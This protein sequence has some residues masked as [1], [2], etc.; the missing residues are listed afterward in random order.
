MK[1][2]MAILLMAAV[3]YSA[4]AKPAAI[5]QDGMVL[6]RER[7]VP[8]WGTEAP[9]AK[10]T[11]SFAGQQKSAV[12]DAAG[13]WR[14]DFD[15]MP[16]CSKPRDLTIVSSNQ[17]ISQSNNRTIL[18]DV[19]VGEVW[20]AS[21]QS[22]MECPIWNRSSHYRD[23]VGAMK[24]AMTRRDDVR[25]F[26]V[27]R[28]WAL[29]PQPVVGS[30]RKFVPS[31]FDMA[32]EDPL[33]SAI[34]FYYALEINQALGVPV[35]I[36]DTCWC[37]TNID[38]W[39][40]LE[41][42]RAMPGLEYVANWKHVTDWKDAKGTH[43]ICGLRQQP[44]VL[45]NGMVADLVPFACRGAIWYQGCHNS[46]EPNDYALKMRALYDGWSKAWG[47]KDFRFY[48]S[49]LA[50]LVQTFVAMREQMKT[51]AA[52]EPNAAM[53]VISDHGCLFNAHPPAKE[54]VARRLALF[55][56]RRDYGFDLVCDSPTVKGWTVE[57]GAFRLELDHARW[58]YWGSDDASDPSGFEIAGADGRF[59][60]AKVMNFD[61]EKQVGSNV[62]VVASSEVKDPKT[63]RFLYS[64]PWKA[65]I[66]SDACLPLGCFELK[67]Q[68]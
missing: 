58:L 28:E 44:G 61:H 49:E 25:F 1:K 59:V 3:S 14:V 65:T 34:A 18:H 6:Q 53:A 47:R 50:P 60:P 4:L 32:K 21:G 52:G 16:A 67:K 64:K 46:D 55:A 17:T 36:V 2:T 66:Y 26:K 48:F 68:R 23:G 63:L 40:P 9:G 57:G 31:S 20:L 7:P 13:K 56:L 8:V 30:W 39:T 41:T 42:I 54:I 45:W 24:I 22:N 5:F 11:V 37:G 35:G 12:A 10:V 33:L 51:F 43:T 29:K 38:A 19:L 15:P 62:L 27:R